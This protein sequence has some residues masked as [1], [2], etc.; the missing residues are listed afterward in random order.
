MSRIKSL[1]IYTFLFW[2]SINIAIVG[3]LIFAVIG[4]QAIIESNLG[5]MNVRVFM[6]VLIQ[7]FLIPC[8]LAFT[9]SAFP[10]YYDKLKIKN[11]FEVPFAEG[12]QQTYPEKFKDSNGVPRN[13]VWVP[14]HEWEDT[15]QF[16][17]FNCSYGVFGARFTSLRSSK[18]YFVKS[19]DLEDIEN[20]MI[21]GKISG[22][23]TFTK[24]HFFH[25]IKALQIY[26]NGS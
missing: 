6:I 22:R 23:F 20:N 3:I 21:K 9:S 15:L 7:V 2:L 10:R 4:D 17:C 1:I 25:S 24:Q 19:S 16:D 11:N 14:N 18:S 26:S 13:P 8:T 12:Y 5:P